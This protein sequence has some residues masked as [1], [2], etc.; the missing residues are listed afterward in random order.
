M[1]A[2]FLLVFLFTRYNSTNST[3]W[4]R[5]IALVSRNQVHVAMEYG[6]TRMFTNIDADIVS[7]GMKTFV[8]FLFNILQHDIHCLTFMIS[9]VKIGCNMAF[10]NNEGMTR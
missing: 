10:R 8:H 3:L 7:I 4:I 6:L 2:G 5:N 9:Q 1:S